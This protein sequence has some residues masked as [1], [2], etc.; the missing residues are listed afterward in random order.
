MFP[1]RVPC[2]RFELTAFWREMTVADDDDDNDK[3]FHLFIYK[4]NGA[5]K[6]KS[7]NIKQMT[8]C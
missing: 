2:K 4:D 8:A 7:V 1:L 5:L 3:N 6:K